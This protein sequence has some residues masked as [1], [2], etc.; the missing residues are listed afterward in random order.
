MKQAPGA[1]FVEMKQQLEKKVFNTI[2][3]AAEEGKT[4]GS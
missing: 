2:F 4:I 1:D 3:I